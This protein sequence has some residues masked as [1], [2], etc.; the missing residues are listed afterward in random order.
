M[1]YSIYKITNTITGKSYVGKTMQQPE[2]RWRQHETGMGHG[3]KMP[4]HLAL[5]KY[6]KENFTFEVVYVCFKEEDVN[7]AEI[8]FINQFNTL[9]PSGY[10]LDFGVT[11]L[12]DNPYLIDEIKKSSAVQSIESDADSSEYNLSTR[13]RYPVELWYTIKDMYQNG[14]SPKDINQKLNLKIPQGSMVSKLRSLGCDTSSKARNK[15]RGKMRF[16]IPTEEKVQIVQDFNLGLKIGQLE[17]KY[18]RTNQTIRQILAADGV[19]HTQDKKIC[20]TIGR[21][22]ELGDKK[23]LG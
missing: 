23:P 12:K 20:R 2:T 10:N 11:Y 4:I 8:Y 9:A 5:K 15:I 18:D 16:V 1:K 17:S 19:Y 21:L 3:K 22:I 14:D 13:T 6:G 7:Y